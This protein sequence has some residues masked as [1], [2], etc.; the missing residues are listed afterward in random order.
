[1]RLANCTMEYLKVV[2]TAMEEHTKLYLAIEANEIGDSAR[3]V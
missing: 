3:G 2:Q 1:M